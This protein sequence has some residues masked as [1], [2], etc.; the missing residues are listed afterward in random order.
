MKKEQFYIKL[1]TDIMPNSPLRKSNVFTNDA[2]EIE[3]NSHKILFTMDDFSEE[4]L[5]YEDDPFTL[6]WNVACAS[7]SD[8]VA[9]GGIPKTYAH[10][11]TISHSWS[12]DFIA[13]FCKGISEVLNRYQLSF[14]GGDLSFSDKWKYT[15]TILGVPTQRVKNRLGI[16]PDDLIFLTGKVGNG[17]LQAA[18][19]LFK[20]HKSFFEI[21]KSMNFKFRTLA[22]Y[23]TVISKFASASID[24]S[25]GI[26]NALQTIADLNGVGFYIHDL[27][28]IKA[29]KES[30]ELLHI[31]E[32]LLAFGECG[33]YEILFTLHPEIEFSF[34]EFMKKNNFQ[35]YKIGKI[36]SKNEKVIE[37]KNSIYNVKDFK[38]EARN[39]SRMKTYLNELI[40]FI[41]N[42]RL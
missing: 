26:V 21:A 10:S 31:N 13:D 11:L 38:Y 39:Y 15:T 16:Q 29:G 22:P 1:I 33:E 40:D 42:C 6:G 35:Y 7:I 28:I 41:H 19:N 14:L 25:D 5:F 4:D 9:S 34:T 12:N 2:E 18:V 3:I 37:Y 17:N 32:L 20:E 30:A 24:T 8:I 23:S 36:S 27:P